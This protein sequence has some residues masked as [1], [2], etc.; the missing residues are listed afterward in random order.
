MRG[1]LRTAELQVAILAV[2]VGLAW[3]IELSDQLLFG[4]TLDSFGIRPRTLARLVGHRRGAAAARRLGAP[5]CQHHSLRGAGV[6]GHAARHPRLLPGNGARR[7]A[8]RPRRVA[9]GAP[10]TVHI[11]ASGLIFGYVGYL[12]GRGYFERSFGSIALA[13]RRGRGLWQRAV[14][15]VA[16]PARHLVGGPPDR[17][18]GRRARREA[19]GGP[20]PRQ[21]RPGAGRLRTNDDSTDERPRR[22]SHRLA[23]SRCRARCASGGARILGL[24]LPS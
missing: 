23:A 16:R 19:A 15:R 13:L 18:P 22:S 11:G 20:A 8:R 10:G 5:A 6:A 24:C 4:G 3:A 12:L 7:A 21:Q 14:G 17:L 9:I 2:C 1:L